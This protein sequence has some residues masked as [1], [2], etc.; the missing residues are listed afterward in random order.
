VID[1][2][3]HMNLE[4]I[5]RVVGKLFLIRLDPAYIKKNFDDK[6]IGSLY[7]IASTESF[8]V[9][10]WGGIRRITFDDGK[11]FN[12]WLIGSIDP[13]DEYEFKPESIDVKKFMAPSIK[14]SLTVFDYLPGGHLPKPFE[15]K[16][17]V[18]LDRYPD[19]KVLGDHPSGT[20]GLDKLY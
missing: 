4:D 16:V 11:P 3:V 6:P 9:Y 20:E 2:K 18:S 1:E 5:M 13:A 7:E 12:Q 8:E 10:S 14:G 19:Y 15:H 17:I